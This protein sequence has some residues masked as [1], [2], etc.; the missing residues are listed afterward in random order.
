MVQLMLGGLG[1][2]HR[3]RPFLPDPQAIRYGVECYH[4]NARISD[5]LQ[6]IGHVRITK[7]LLLI[8]FCFQAIWCR[9]RHGVDT[10]YYIPAPGKRT[11]LYRDWV[12]LSLCR[13]FFRRTVLHWHAAGLGK[14]LEREANHQT[15]KVTFAAYKHADLSLVLSDFNRL[16]AEKMLALRVEKVPN[17]I[18]D[19]C[20]GFERELLPRRKARAMARQRLLAGQSLTPSDLAETGGNPEIIQVLFLGH[21]MRTKGLFDAVEMVAQANENYKKAGLPLR[22]HLNVAGEFVDPA[23]RAEFDRLIQSPD[24]R[25]WATY[26]GFVSGKGKRKVLQESDCLCFPTHYAAESFGLVLVEAMAFGLSIVSTRWRSIPELFPADYPGLVEICRPD[27]GAAALQKLMC[28]GTGE[29]MRALFLERFTL[30]RFLGRLGKVL[31]ELET[32]PPK[33]REPW[34]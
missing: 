11:A 8:G 18:P 4:V 32:N 30:D 25:S 23:E 16:D 6:D 22:V 14:W 7:F 3:Q 27:Q 1:G 2:D 20:P 34:N 5:N 10:L 17:G 13:P 21:C 24:G 31:C 26:L 28:E 29:E 9:F 19:P 15:R 12:V 33:S